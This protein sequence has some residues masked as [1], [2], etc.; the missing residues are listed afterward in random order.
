MLSVNLSVNE[1]INIYN[2]L[3]NCNL[4]LRPEAQIGLGPP[5]LLYLHQRVDT[6]SFAGTR[7]T[8]SHH[9]VAYSL[10]LEQLNE[11][12]DPGRPVDELGLVRL[13]LDLSLHLRVA[14]VII[15]V[16]LLINHYNKNK[17]ANYF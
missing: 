11:L 6:L 7:W 14:F 9:A 8:Q 4:C 5:F 15:K 3:H 12:E 13:L 16:T 10:C 1:L 17:L 2:I